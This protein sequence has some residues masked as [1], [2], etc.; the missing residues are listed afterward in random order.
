LQ[1]DYA[2]DLGLLT[3]KT[4]IG[5]YVDNQLVSTYANTS[6]NAALNWQA[7]SF[8]FAGNGQCRNIRI[9]LEGG[10]AVLGRG[11]MIDALRVIETL[12]SQGGIVYGMVNQWVQLS[13]IVANLTDTD[14]SETLALKLHAIPRGS[15]ISDG[16]H[17]FTATT[18]N[19]VLNL[20]GWN[21]AALMYKAPSSCCGDIQL[22][23]VATSTEQ[24]TGQSASIMRTMTI[25]QLSGTATATPV[26]VNPY[27]TTTQPATITTTPN[28]AISSLMTVGACAHS[29]GVVV[30]P[31]RGIW[32]EDESIDAQHAEDLSDAW[33]TQLELNAQHNW[34]Q[35]LGL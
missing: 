22:Q 31:P 9:Q 20:T 14:G 18:D 23:V 4:R 16:V 7:L 33:L 17:S 3:D 8:Q 21:T 27:V 13:H 32:R 10:N 6:T 19:A 34:S 15:M 35:F 11:A 25:K 12:P 5:I 26:G 1:L 2:G 24:S 29:V 28:I 30:A